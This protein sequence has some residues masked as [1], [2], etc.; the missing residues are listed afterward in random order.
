MSADFRVRNW[1]QSNHIATEH[2]CK[3]DRLPEL[4]AEAAIAESAATNILG[5]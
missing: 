3:N 1:Q 2:A 4:L 5:F